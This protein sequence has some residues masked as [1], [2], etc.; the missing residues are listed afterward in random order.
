VCSDHGTLVVVQLISDDDDVA[1]LS[2]GV[3]DPMAGA[4]RLVGLEDL[5]V[6]ATCPRSSGCLCDSTSSVVGVTPPGSYPCIR[7]TGSDHSQRW[8]A[9]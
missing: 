1:D 2:A 8:S 6:A 5:M 3:D 4:E 7:W 9:K